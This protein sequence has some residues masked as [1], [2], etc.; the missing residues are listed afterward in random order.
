M[1]K[2]SLAYSGAILLALIV[3]AVLLNR[4]VIYSAIVSSEVTLVV[5]TGFSDVPLGG[6]WEGT[7]T[8]DIGDAD[9]V[10]DS[11]TLKFVST[12][13]D[14]AGTP[15]FTVKLSLDP[16]TTGY[17]SSSPSGLYVGSKRITG[18]GKLK[19]TL[20]PEGFNTLGGTLATLGELPGTGSLEVTSIGV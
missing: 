9:E 5:D 18:K 6:T 16:G 13:A 7:A 1:S 20:V 8:I 2:K 11:V 12:Q 3:T 17:N 10:V 19:V 4:G 15:D 14:S